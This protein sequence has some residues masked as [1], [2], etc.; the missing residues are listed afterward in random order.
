MLQYLWTA[1]DCMLEE[2]L[3][4]ERMPKNFFQ[5]LFIILEVLWA[6]GQVGLKGGGGGSLF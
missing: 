1:G 3:R 4:P 5:A 2:S 6:Q